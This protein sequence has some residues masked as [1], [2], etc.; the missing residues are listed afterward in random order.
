[1][2]EFFRDAAAI[3]IFFALVLLFETVNW[4]TGIGRGK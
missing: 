2:K 4:L 1:M 3:L